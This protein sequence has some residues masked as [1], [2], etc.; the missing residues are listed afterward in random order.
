MAGEREQS[1]VWW[2]T[3]KTS[4]GRPSNGAESDGIPEQDVVTLTPFCI[5]TYSS[6]HSDP[7]Q[8]VPWRY[9][10][11]IRP[12]SLWESLSKYRNLT[13]RGEQYSVHQYALISRNREPGVPHLHHLSETDCVGRIIEIRAADPQNVYARV[14]W[15][16][17]PEDVPGGRQPYHGEDELISSNLMEIVDALTFKK[18]VRVVHWMQDDGTP[19]R[20]PEEGF[21]WRQKWDWIAEKLVPFPTHC[22]CDKPVSLH[23][24]TIQ[25]TNPHCLILLHGACLVEHELR[26]L[27][28]LLGLYDPR[29]SRD[30]STSRAD[31]TPTTGRQISISAADNGRHYR[32]DIGESERLDHIGRTRFMFTDLRDPRVWETDIK[33]LKCGENIGSR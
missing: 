28:T 5:D 4:D 33:C 7:T 22:V 11:Q 29:Q 12:Q 32:V 13:V 23:E 30:V 18:P 31:P 25:C 14:F 21:Y 17:R 15:V 9:A 1:A 16:L 19:R 26:K 6:P 10:I 27:L 20:A 3:N 24:L 8:P 2:P